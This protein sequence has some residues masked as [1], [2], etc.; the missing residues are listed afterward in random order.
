[1][2][3]FL[4]LLLQGTQ[5]PQGVV[6]PAVGAQGPQGP[7]GATGTQGP[8]GGGVGPQGT[9]GAGGAQGT[10]GPQGGGTGT[11][12]TQG[13]QGVQGRSPKS[14]YFAAGSTTPGSS[15]VPYY[16]S[17]TPSAAPSI[18]AGDFY[19]I[20]PYDL[21]LKALFWRITTAGSNPNTYEICA[22]VNDVDTAVFLSRS[23]T[24]ASGSITGQNVA[25]TAGQ[26]VSV[27]YQ[28]TVAGAAPNNGNVFCTVSYEAR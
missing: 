3:R 7:Q 4:R 27:R 28:R 16:L 14:F 9:Q 21:V 12:G 25:V 1:M 19:F 8:Q 20:A 17:S 5:G 15:T 23:G 18:T 13:P 26:R 11:Q 10:Q 22:Q 2:E 24:Q 6:G